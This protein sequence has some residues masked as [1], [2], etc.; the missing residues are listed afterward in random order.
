MIPRKTIEEYVGRLV[1]RFCPE[2]VILFGSQANGNANADSD[3][4][5]LVV[6]NHGK[7]RDVDEEIEIDR[8]LPRGFPLDILVWKPEE[9]RRRLAAGDMALISMLRNG[10]TLYERR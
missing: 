2:S 8:A 3:V 6:M 7:T 10:E 5:L 4:D 9:L 1:D